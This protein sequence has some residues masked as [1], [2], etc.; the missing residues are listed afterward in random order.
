MFG[1]HEWLTLMTRSPC[2]RAALESPERFAAL[3]RQRTRLERDLLE[4]DLQRSEGP[5]PAQGPRRLEHPPSCEQ[6][7]AAR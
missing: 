6:D 7:P 1:H 5:S 3:S 4:R 2:L